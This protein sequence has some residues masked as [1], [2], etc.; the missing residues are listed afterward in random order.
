MRRFR[1]SL[2]ILI[3][4][5]AAVSF[6]GITPAIAE[7]T[8]WGGGIGAVEYPDADLDVS[9]GGT[10]KLSSDT[11]VMIGISMGTS[12]FAP[13]RFEGELAYRTNDGNKL[14]GPG[15]GVSGNADVH[16]AGLMFNGYYD[17]KN[18]SSITPFLGIGAGVA[19]V[20]IDG[21]VDDHDSVFAYQFIAGVGFDINPKLKFDLSYKY[22]S[23]AT[24]SF[25]T[26][27]NSFDLDYS[28]H[29]LQ[30]GLRYY[31]IIL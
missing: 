17:F 28:T 5:H 8:Y 19:V 14:T 20:D 3:F 31:S 25:K 27:G 11:G 7:D 15:G 26:G 24:P 9:G 6:I 16:S 22:F 12:K 2:F 4:L 13:F 21:T 1:N 30:I 29:S 23:T 18:S 10:A